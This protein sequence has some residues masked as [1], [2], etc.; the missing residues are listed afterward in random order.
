[1]SALRERQTQLWSPLI[2]GHEASFRQSGRNAQDG[3][4]WGH[5]GSLTKPLS[6]AEHLPHV[7]GENIKKLG[8]RRERFHIHR[9]E[10]EKEGPLDEYPGVR[11]EEKRKEHQVLSGSG[12]ILGGS[13]RGRGKA[14]YGQE[15]F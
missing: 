15:E 14:D 10:N 8:G 5:N 12:G 4:E 2:D 6:A 13:F 11:Y 3:G 9:Y 7:E 1:M